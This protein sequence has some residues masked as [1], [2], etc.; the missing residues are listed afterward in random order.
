MKSHVFKCSKLL[1]ANKLNTHHIML[2]EA[3]FPMNLVFLVFVNSASPVGNFIQVS[4]S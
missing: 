4:V 1:G 2:N 3:K